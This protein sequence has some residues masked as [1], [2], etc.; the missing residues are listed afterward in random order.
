MENVEFDRQFR[1]SEAFLL[2]G[3]DEA[4]RG[5][6]A[7]PVCAAAVILPPDFELDGL[8]DSKK[9]TE[10]KREKLFP[11]ICE[12]AIAYSIA[13]A[14]VEEIEEY[15]ILQATFLAMKRAVDGLGVRPDHILVDGDKLPPSLPSSAQPLIK[16]D[17]LSASVAAASVLAKVSRDR[18][19]YELDAQYPQYGFAAHKGYGTKVHCEAILKHGVLPCHRLSF[20]KKLLAKQEG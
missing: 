4:G 12:N 7:G 19:M 2:C 13:F 3:V 16:G 5:P 1:T 15:N 20:L 11:I 9:L 10:K 6:F 17:A 18:L 14:T 8:N